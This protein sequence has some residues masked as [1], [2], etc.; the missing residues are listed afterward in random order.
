MPVKCHIFVVVDFRR[1]VAPPVVV[2]DFRR[3]GART[4]SL[5]YRSLQ[6]DQIGRFFTFW[7]TLIAKIVQLLHTLALTVGLS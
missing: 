6:C 5:L 1:S 7:A 3:S 4:S 2:V